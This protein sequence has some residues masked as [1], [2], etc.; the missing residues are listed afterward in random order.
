MLLNALSRTSDL[1]FDLLVL[2]AHMD[3]IRVSVSAWAFFHEPLC[4]GHETIRTLCCLCPTT[5][6]A[7]VMAEGS[8]QAYECGGFFV[9]G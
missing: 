5:Q 7:R 1:E 3:Q 9:L 6:T 8:P 2:E 4:H